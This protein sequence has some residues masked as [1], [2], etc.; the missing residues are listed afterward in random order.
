[1]IEILKMVEKCKNFSKNKGSKGSPGTG[2]LMK[3]F[4]QGA[5]IW[6]I[7]KICP[8]VDRGMVT[9]GIDW[10]IITLCSKQ[11]WEFKE[12]ILFQR[13][14][15]PYLVIEKNNIQILPGGQNVSSLNQL[16]PKPVP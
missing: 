10:D 16:K 5:K 15:Q 6:Q 3:K 9:L 12:N 8:K 4:A 7:L 14:T 1:M 11:I 13:A 2:L